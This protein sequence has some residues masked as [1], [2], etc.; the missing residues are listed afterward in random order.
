MFFFQHQFMKLK[1]KVK[2]W[3]LKPRCSFSLALKWP[4]LHVELI[5][6]FFIRCCKVCAKVEGEPCGGAG[7]FHGKCQPP[8]KCI[9]R[10]PVIGTGICLSNLNSQISVNSTIRYSKKLRYFYLQIYLLQISRAISS[11]KS[12]RG[13]NVEIP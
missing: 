3:S 2:S 8:L 4:E 9:S 11:D 1:M 7:G 5:Y 6:E 10:P 13:K 12:T